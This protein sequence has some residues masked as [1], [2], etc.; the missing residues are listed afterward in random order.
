MTAGSYEPSLADLNGLDGVQTAL[1]A[2][3]AAVARA[4][5][6]DRVF[7]RGVVEISNLCRENCHYCGMR[8]ENRSLD[9]Y[10][11]D[12]DRLAELLLDHRPRSMTDLN[13][14]AGEDPVAVREVALPLIRHIRRHTT[15]GVSVCLGTLDEGLYA[16]L[17]EAGAE[18]YILKFETADPEHYGRCEGPGTLA[19]R[20]R[21]IRRLAASGW[22]VSS[23]FIAGLPGARPEALLHNCRF[24]AA[25]PLRGCSVSPF[26]PGPATPL[27]GA[28]GGP[29]DQTLNC[30]AMLR[31]LRPD[32]VIPSVSALNIA[33]PKRGYRRGLRA[34]ANLVTINLT[35]PELRAEYVLY[36]PDRFIMTEQRIL[37]ALE[38]EGLVPSATSLAEHFRQ[39]TRS[40]AA[41]APPA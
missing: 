18:I 25:L 10:R 41:V 8:R 31:L 39:S 14:Q 30:M 35:P 2:R 6:G 24:A 27:A 12:A 7:V 38:A 40:P 4:R 21:H 29:A 22:S 16:A 36:K 20:V 1:H 15:L 28:V 37:E 34:G 17:R 3:A 32:W 9:R 19:E 33:E 5:F 13:L 23:G 11:A 26:V